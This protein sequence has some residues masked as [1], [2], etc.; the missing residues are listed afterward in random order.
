M[1]R[2]SAW[3]LR[4]PQAIEEL[5]RIPSPVLDRRLIERLLGLSPRQ[6]LRVMNR[7]SP[8]VMG[9]S[10][11]VDRAKVLE[12]FRE[13]VAGQEWHWENTRRRRLEGHLSQIRMDRKAQEVEIPVSQ[14]L[15]N[16]IRDLPENFSLTPGCLIVRFNGALDLLRL[17]YDFSQACAANFTELER[18]LDP[19]IL[20]AGDV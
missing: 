19:S 5:E 6:A 4:I 15:P 3:S 1:P 20:P 8:I 18:A 13:V 12:A 2:K 14:T 9:K 7:L 17:L 11:V 16:T 10:T